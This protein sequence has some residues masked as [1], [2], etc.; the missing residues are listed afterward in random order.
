MA[1]AKSTFEDLLLSLSYR[2]GESSTPPSGI[3]NR[4]YWLNRGVNY[5]LDRLKPVQTDTITVASGVCDLTSGAG[6]TLDFRSFV[7]L[8]DSNNHSIQ[9]VS[10]DQYAHAEG[11]VCSITGNHTSG[12]TLNVKTDGTYTLWYRFYPSDMTADGDVCIV[13][14]PEAVVAFAYAQIRRSETDPL[15]DVDKNLQECEDRINNMAE[16]LSRNEGALTF[17][18][19]Y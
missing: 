7:S 8:L 15:G 6:T 16:E 17:K 3:E 19:L 18:T 11:N 13:S 5:V 9:I 2:Y 10:P 14:D 12:F 1:Y 4:K